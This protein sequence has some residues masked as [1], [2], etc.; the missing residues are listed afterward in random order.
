MK[1]YSPEQKRAIQEKMLP[2]HN[3]SVS[4]LAKKMESLK[5]HCMIGEKSHE[6]KP[7]NIRHYQISPF[8]NYYRITIKRTIKI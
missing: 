8:R 3:V 2:P 6:K 1:H 4:F 5:V 7:I